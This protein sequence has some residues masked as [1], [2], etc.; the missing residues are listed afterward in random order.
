MRKPTI[1]PHPVPGSEFSINKV[2]L[3]FDG[4]IFFSCC[5][6]DG[7]HFVCLLTHEDYTSG[8]RSYIMVSVSPER[9]HQLESGSID[10]RQV[11]TLAESGLVYIMTDT[12]Q[13]RQ[14]EA[15]L[16]SQIG[17]EYLPGPGQ[18]LR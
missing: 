3:Y 17:H 13:G 8:A 9:K 16:A 10:T 7:S 4:A 18:K 6:P 2:Y 12:D 14:F 5:M 11:Y 1:N 15:K